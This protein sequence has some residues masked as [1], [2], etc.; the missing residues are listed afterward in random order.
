MVAKAREGLGVGVQGWV[1]VTVTVKGVSLKGGASHLTGKEPVT[2]RARDLQAACLL[3]TN[4]G[5][6]GKALPFSKGH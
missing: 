2:L 5:C 3:S 6:A 4:G 1:E